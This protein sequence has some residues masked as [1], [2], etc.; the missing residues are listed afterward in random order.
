MHLLTAAAKEANLPMNGFDGQ[1]I[2]WF[3][4]PEALPNI[5]WTDMT[6]VYV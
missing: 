2:E 5:M 4:P 1:P 3:D 6:C